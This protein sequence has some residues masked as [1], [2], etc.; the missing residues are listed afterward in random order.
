[1][2]PPV[3]NINTEGLLLFVGDI[4]NLKDAAIYQI[5]NRLRAFAVVISATCSTGTL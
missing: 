2:V 5:P 1:M 4:L 3:Y